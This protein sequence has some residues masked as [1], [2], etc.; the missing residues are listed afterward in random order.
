MRG[1]FSQVIA[2]VQL[3]G[4]FAAWQTLVE[5]MITTIITIQSTIVTINSS[6]SITSVKYN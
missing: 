4:I 5:T 2:V 6:K 1:Q 3:V